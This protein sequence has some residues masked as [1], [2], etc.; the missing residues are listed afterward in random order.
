MGCAAGV[1]AGAKIA[2]ARLITKMLLRLDPK[3][4]PDDG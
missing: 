3:G 2:Q 1:A 4:E